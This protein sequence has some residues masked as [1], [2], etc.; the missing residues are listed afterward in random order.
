MAPLSGA[1]PSSFMPG[2]IALIAAFFFAN[3]S[4]GS[5]AACSSRSTSAAISVIASRM[6]ARLSSGLGSSGGKETT[7]VAMGFR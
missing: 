2:I 4:L 5:L 3:A 7:A 1:S 6:T